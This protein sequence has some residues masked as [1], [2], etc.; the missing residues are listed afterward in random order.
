MSRTTIADRVSKH[1]KLT[2]VLFAA[3]LALSQVGAAAAATG[4]TLG[5]P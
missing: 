2:G 1:P 5:G 4:S 3:L